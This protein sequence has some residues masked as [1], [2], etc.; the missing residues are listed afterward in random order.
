MQTLMD[1]IEGEEKLTW[2]EQMKKA[3]MLHPGKDDD[4]NIEDVSNFD[5]I[6]HFVSCFWKV[7]FSL[8]PPP[9]YGG[10]FPCFII[11]LVFIGLCTLVV[12]EVANLMGCVMF[13]KPGVTAITFVAIGTSIPDTFASRIAAQQER[14][15][16]EAVGNVTGSNS[17]NVFLGLGL[18]WVIASIYHQNKG[19]VFYH[20][21]DGLDLSVAL[22]LVV[23]LIGIAV[24][25]I[26][27]QVV[28]GELGGSARGRYISAFI[29]ISL[30]FIYVIISSLAQ[31][32]IISFAK[33]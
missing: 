3:V 15:G 25:V 30:W 21:A 24:L 2:T 4:G 20:P 10:G 16:D 14:Y 17:V 1:R 29:F 31:Y 23:S 26:R 11:A 9:H 13:L 7:L 22:F 5:A 28:G 19:T 27:R 18:P 33:E 8:C 6:F 12:A 32:K